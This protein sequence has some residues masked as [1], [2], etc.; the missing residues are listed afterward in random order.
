MNAYPLSPLI[1]K[2]FEAFIN[3]DLKVIEGIIS[4]NVSLKDWSA[5][6]VGKKD[7]LDMFANIFK[8]FH[9]ID[10]HILS[11]ID[12]GAKSAVEMLIY[13]DDIN[14]KVVDIITYTENFISEISAYKQ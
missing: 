5:I 7:V 2:Y 13:L 4:E 12:N 14:I 3:K 6:A 10:V 9:K 8:T 11:N 1:Q